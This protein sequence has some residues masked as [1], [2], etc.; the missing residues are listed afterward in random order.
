MDERRGLVSIIYCIDFSFS[1]APDSMSLRTIVPPSTADGN[2]K[3]LLPHKAPMMLKPKWHAPWKL[4][5]V[6]SGHTGWVRCVDVEPGNE[7]FVT[8]GADRIIKVYFCP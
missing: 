6:I 1:T 7:W 4:Y 2:I 3:A 8:G 5:R